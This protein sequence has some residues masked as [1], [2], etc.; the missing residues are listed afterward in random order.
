M[1]K[2]ANE[3]QEIGLFY[4]VGILMEEGKSLTWYLGR[5]QKMVKRHEKSTGVDYVRFVPTNEPGIQILLK[6]YKH[7]EGLQYSYI[8]Y[9][10][11]EADFIKLKHAIC[12][13]G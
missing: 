11:Y 8:G 4:D 10:G 2:D 3:I 7:I 12:L 5:I 1:S 6:Y 13:V 9:S